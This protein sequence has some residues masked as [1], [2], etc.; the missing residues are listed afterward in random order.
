MEQAKSVVDLILQNTRLIGSITQNKKVLRKILALPL[1]PDRHISSHNNTIGRCVRNE[2]NT[3]IRN[4]RERVKESE[5]TSKELLVIDRCNDA[6]S[7]FFNFPLWTENP[8]TL[9]ELNEAQ[10][11][12][13]KMVDRAS[14]ESQV[15]DNPQSWTSTSPGSVEFESGGHISR[16]FLEVLVSCLVGEELSEYGRVRPS[17]AKQLR[18]VVN[19]EQGADTQVKELQETETVK[20]KKASRI[21]KKVP[22]KV[23]RRNRKVVDHSGSEGEYTSNDN[24]KNTTEDSTVANQRKQIFKVNSNDPKVTLERGNATTPVSNHTNSANNLL[25]DIKPS[26]FISGPPSDDYFTPSPI[27]SP[28]PSTNPIYD[29]HD[30]SIPSPQSPPVVMATPS[31]AS[32]ITVLPTKVTTKVPSTVY[33]TLRNIDLLEADIA[34]L[35]PR[36][37]LNDTI[38]D[39]EMERIRLSIPVAERDKFLFVSVFVYSTQ[40]ATFYTKSKKKEGEDSSQRMPWPKC[41]ISKVEHIIMPVHLNE[42]HYALIVLRYPYHICKPNKNFTP[43]MIF[44]N[45][46]ASEEYFQDIEW[47]KLRTYVNSLLTFTEKRDIRVCSEKKMPHLHAT[48]PQQDNGYDCGLFV[49][50]YARLYVQNPREFN[51]HNADWFDSTTMV[52][53][54]DL[55]G[56]LKELHK[57]QKK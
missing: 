57:K 18:K 42:N 21:V 32:P 33:V 13:N 43:E 51:I 52:T 37:W 30:I 8:T 11:L 9:D 34:T 25:N 23:K 2:L 22:E 6:K 10:K 40:I 46:L 55:L 54:T 20:T 5:R 3:K 38:I 31:P 14:K 56:V 47:S 27:Q 15:L 26:T 12:T 35:Q 19:T 44:M 50:H 36:Q 1:R 39:F 16:D 41:D 4:G 29:F 17:I 49:L 7:I 24:N 53:R 28:V 45:S 48:V